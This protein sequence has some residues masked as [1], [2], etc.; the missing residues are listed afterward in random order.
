MFNALSFTVRF[1]VGKIQNE[2]FSLENVPN[3]FNLI[4]EVSK[5]V[6]E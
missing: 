4:D 6:A 2:G 3:L 1:Y 5:L